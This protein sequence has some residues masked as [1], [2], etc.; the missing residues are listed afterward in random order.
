M[1]FFLDT[2]FIE[3]GPYIP[4][5][6]VSIGIVSDEGHEFYAVSKEFDAESASPWVEAN[7][8][9]HLLIPYA[10]RRTLKDIADGIRTFIWNMAGDDRLEFWGYY[11]DYDWV[12]FCQLFGSMM[13]LPQAFPKYCMDIKQWAV[14][15]GDPQ[16]PAKVGVEH[17]ALAD[18]KW[19]KVAWEFLNTYKAVKFN[20]TACN[21]CGSDFYNNDNTLRHFYGC[22]RTG[23]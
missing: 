3:N 18:A 15:L 10:C 9:P 21:Q 16:L 12:V 13:N 17:N 22:P 4:I 8:L 19:N 5:Q 11:S 1:K 14:S 2:E 7:V 6:L 20:T 23:V